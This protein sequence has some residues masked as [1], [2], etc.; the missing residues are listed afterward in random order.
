[1]SCLSPSDHL[2]ICQTFEPRHVVQKFDPVA[3]HATDDGTAGIGAEIAAADTRRERKGLAQCALAVDHQ[4]LAL[5]DLHSL[6]ALGVTQGIA[7]HRHFLQ[8]LRI[9]DRHVLGL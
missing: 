6:Y 5:Q 4:L 9:C 8:S 7:R 2:R 3:V 1:M